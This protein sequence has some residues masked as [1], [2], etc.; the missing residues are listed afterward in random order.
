M[1][2]FSQAITIKQNTGDIPNRQSKYITY[3]MELY[4][5]YRIY[6]EVPQENNVWTDEKG[7]IGYTEGVM[8]DEANPTDR[9]ESVQRFCVYV[10]GN[11]AK[12]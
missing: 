1:I 7:Y 12:V 2:K 3:T 5:P 6:S 10:C 8:R 4:V 9:W 11:L